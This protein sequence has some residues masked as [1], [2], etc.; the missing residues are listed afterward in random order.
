M[1]IIN[2]IITIIF[3][4]GTI[5][6]VIYFVKRDAGKNK[7][8]IYKYIPRTLEEEQNEP[9]FVSEIFKAMFT[10]P[11]VWIDAVEEDKKRQTGKFN[12]YFISQT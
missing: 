12:D 3:F 6:L 5:F 2:G 9:V 8:I 1:A 10:Q 4:I 11:S 7:E